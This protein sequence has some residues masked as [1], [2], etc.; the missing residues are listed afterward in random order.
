MNR[1]Q[2]LQ[3][4]IIPFA[5]MLLVFS[6][7]GCSVAQDLPATS[8]PTS[9]ST[10]IPTY[11]PQP[12]LTPTHTPQPSLTPSPTADIAQLFEFD[13]EAMSV[14]WSPDGQILAVGFWEGSIVLLDSST[15]EQLRTIETPGYIFNVLWSPN[16]E[17]LASGL[18][19]ESMERTIILWEAST[20]Q[21]LERQWNNT[22][23]SGMAWSPNGR[24]LSGG[25]GNDVLLWGIPIEFAAFL[26]GHTD[27]VASTTWSPD[28]QTLASGSDDGR[29]ILWDAATGLQLRTIECPEY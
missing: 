24:T 16:G 4:K 23:G 3:Q 18:L 29:I 17:V 14:A 1:E 19:V 25:I 20:G 5:V 10:L 15:G 21:E 11:T 7:R 13:G 22:S 9:L 28:G 12:S 8:T 26:E 2:L 27:R 6:N